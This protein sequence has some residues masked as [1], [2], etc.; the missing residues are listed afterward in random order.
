[1]VKEFHPT[2]LS[3]LTDLTAKK[4]PGAAEELVRHRRVLLFYQSQKI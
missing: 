4:E 1:V 3:R 2:S